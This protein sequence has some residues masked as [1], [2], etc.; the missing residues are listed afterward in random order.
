[1]LEVK[2]KNS[3]EEFMNYFVDSLS[4]MS[5]GDRYGFCALTKGDAFQTAYSLLLKE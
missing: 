3:C 2:I 4:L 1:M 5:I